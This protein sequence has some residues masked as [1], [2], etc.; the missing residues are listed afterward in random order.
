MAFHLCLSNDLEKLADCFVEKMCLPLAGQDP[1]TEVH[2]VVPNNGMSTFLKRRL[3]GKD[4]LGI[5]ANLSCSFLQKFIN[6]TLEG[7]FSAD[8]LQRFKETLRFWSPDVLCWHIDTLLASSKGGAFQSYTDYWKPQGS[9]TGDPLKRHLLARELANCFD[10]YQLY[11]SSCAD[12]ARHLERWRAGKD[13]SP[14]ARLYYELCRTMPDPDSF[15]SAFFSL[16]APRKALPERIGVFGVSSMAA[17]HLHCLKKFAEHTE[18][19]LFTPSPCSGYWGDIMSRKELLQELKSDPERA[20]EY[21]ENASTQNPLLADFGKPGR[22]FLNLLLDQGC[23]SG[24]SDEELFRDPA[25]DGKGTVLQRFQSD[26]LNIRHRICAEDY[27][28]EDNTIR[29]NSC[30]DSRRE[31]EILHDQLLE[32]FYGS[33]NEKEKLNPEEVIVMFPDINSAAPM[34]DAVFSAGPLKGKY[35]ICDRSTAGQSQ[36]IDCFTRLLGLPGM[37]CTSDDILS[38]LEYDCLSS[39]LGLAQ[40]DMPFLIELTLRARINWGL[41]E[42]EHSKFRQNAF[43]EFSWQDG[44]ERLLNEYARG[45]DTSVL[46]SV[47]ESGGI[48]GGNADIFGIVAEFISK[49]REWRSA[50]FRSRTPEEWGSFLC[51]WCDTF[52]EGGEWQYKAE[53]S[54]LKRTINQLVRNAAAADEKMEIAPEVFIA[55]VKSS[56]S[57]TGGRQNFLRDKITFCSL[58]PLRAIPAKVIAVMGLNDGEFPGTSHRNSFDLLSTVQ[59]NDPNN[60]NDKRYLY[61]EALMAAKKYL[62]LSYV[63]VDEGKAIDPAVPLAATADVLA[64]GFN[65]KAEEIPLRANELDPL[66]AIRKEST[67]AETAK[68][69][70]PLAPMEL[71]AAISLRFLNKLLSKQCQEFFKLHYGFDYREKNSSAA[72]NDD[73]SEINALDQSKLCSALWEQRLL[74]GKVELDEYTLRKSRILPVNGRAILERCSNLVAGISGEIA[75]NFR[76]AK[77][78]ELRLFLPDLNVELYAQLDVPECPGDKIERKAVRFSKSALDKQFSFYLEQLL[79][80]AVTGKEV[81]GTISFYTLDSKTSQPVEAHAVFPPVRDPRRALE[82]ILAVALRTYTEPEPLPFFLNA[83][84]MWIASDEDER[85]TLKALNKDFEN[86]RTIDLFFSKEEFEN[87]GF[88]PEFSELADEVLSDFSPLEA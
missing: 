82:K 45:E 26:I 47:A 65:L 40:K 36:L 28:P 27:K 73:P 19:Y 20:A 32:L 4:S 52:F 39:K 75:E 35:S 18:L 48:D 61:L 15:Y 6:A 23:F 12:P 57:V 38:L 13:N 3:A 80:A 74:D 7:Y 31:V 11:R 85:E 53:L 43:H 59:R 77:K 49:L 22:E 86:D 67:V 62:I 88:P 1:F 81:S 78:E 68:N 56:C 64:E 71:P 30:P 87:G 69:E 83:S 21:L 10:R 66:L 54:E 55:A 16:S 70:V 50:L 79:V 42:T 33:Q 51:E 17:L 29:I 9:K 60:A 72:I 41:D 24:E 63:G 14:Q 44:V 34:I 58:V 2:T 5:A 25:P 76:S 84:R 37:K 8:E 46:N